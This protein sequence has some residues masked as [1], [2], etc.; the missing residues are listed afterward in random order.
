[1]VEG[2]GPTLEDE[3][4]AFS[5]ALISAAPDAYVAAQ[6]ARAHQHL[7]LQPGT[8]FDRVLLALAARGPWAFRAADGYARI[9]APTSAL[10]RKLSVLVAILEAASPSDAAFAS[11][12]KPRAA[13]I[14][15][16]LLTGVGFAL[17][18]GVGV[19]VLA[20]IHLASRLKGG[21]A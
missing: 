3:A 21:S 14:V 13:V 16:L 4:H 5:L 2:A 10:R 7:P 19:I 11:A 17:L 12:E 18:L 20:P 15:Q 6:Y 1:M 9:F 8:P